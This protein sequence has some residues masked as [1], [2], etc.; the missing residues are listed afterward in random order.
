MITSLVKILYSGAAQPERARN[1]KTLILSALYN[2]KS[3]QFS[4]GDATH[5][6]SQ[7]LGKMRQE[8]H[9]KPRSLRLTRLAYQTKTKQIKALQ[10][11]TMVEDFMEPWSSWSWWKALKSGR[12]SQSRLVDNGR[13]RRAHRHLDYLNSHGS[14]NKTYL[15]LNTCFNFK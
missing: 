11:R 7:F 13:S 15:S 6:L 1:Y 5:I 2:M 4:G 10:T 12:R 3:D 9:W 14:S 8:D